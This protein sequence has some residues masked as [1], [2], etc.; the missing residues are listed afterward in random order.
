M[1]MFLGLAI[2]LGL[3]R[4]LGEIAR[5]FHQPAV[6]GEIVAGVLLGPSVLGAA[7]P[8]ANVWLYPLDGPILHFRQGFETFAVAM[9]LLVAGMEVDLRTVIRQGKT[10]ISVSLLGMIVPFAIGLYA[11]WLAP[12]LLGLH[13]GADPFVFM[14]FIATAL[15]ISALPVI[16]R[17]L[18]DLELFRTDL[19]MIIV[20]SAI[21]Q[22]LAGWII[23]AI[24]LGLMDATVSD[25]PVAATVALT[26]GFAVAMLTVVRWLVH[27]AL[28]LVQAYASWPGGVL[29]FSITFALLC[30]ALTELFGLHA[31]FGTFFA[32]VVLGA[33]RHLRERTR[34]TI[35]QFVS[36]VLAPLFFGGI[37]LK[38]DFVSH[39]DLVLVIV[40]LVVACV[41]KIAGC[42][43]GARLAGMEER[44]A[45]A[46]GFG[47]NARGAMEIIL[48]LLA[49][50][51]GVISERLFVAL[52]VMALITSM[53]AGP[54]MQR[55]LN[56]RRR[57]RFFDYVTPAMFLPHVRADSSGAMIAE[58]SRVAAQACGLDAN[59]VSD[60]VQHRE[61]LMPT[62]LSDGLAVPHARVQGLQRPIVAV[63]VA[64]DGVDFGS[65]DGTPSEA[66]F[67]VLTPEDDDGTQLELIA[68]ISRTFHRPEMRKRLM[69]V[70]SYVEFVALSRTGHPD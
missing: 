11:A 39:F 51:Y 21:V 22:D 23:F 68:D 31:I 2:L 14:L 35:D 28:L 37:G 34:A 19:G 12:E 15:S 62:G 26:L 3:A 60:A 20:A 24:I 63:G 57:V 30:G 70:A 6:L 16:A 64:P 65:P 49:L 53:L 67:L 45:W 42:V 58:M 4:L 40:V 52:V 17:T 25:L 13:A 36:S 18:L 10:A 55:A 61:A 8:V 5:R 29:G 50:Q 69:Q 66:V 41:G 48:G 38:V 32:G 1:V 33:S 59:A 56:R 54:L 43:V 9:F 46:V 47:M 7:W 27:R 44:E